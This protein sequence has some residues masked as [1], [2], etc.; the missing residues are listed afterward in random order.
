MRG[1]GHPRGAEPGVAGHGDR[2]GSTHRHGRGVRDARG[3]RA[4]RRP[5]RALDHR[6]P[7]RLRRRAGTAFVVPARLC[8]RGP[9]GGRFV[10]PIARAIFPA[11]LFGPGGLSPAVGGTRIIGTPVIGTPVIGTSNLGSPDLV[12]AGLLRVCGVIGA[13]L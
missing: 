8:S 9:A 4:E 6:F 1:G 3:A 10:T 7:G 12:G 5:G 13:F 11:S 2:D